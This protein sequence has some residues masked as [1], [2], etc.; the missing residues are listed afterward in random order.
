MQSLS[1]VKKQPLMKPCSAAPHPSSPHHLRPLFP[2]PRSMLMWPKGFSLSARW[3][4][5]HALAQWLGL[6][7][8]G[9]SVKWFFL[10]Q[11][12]CFRPS[13]ILDCVAVCLKMYART[14]LWKPGEKKINNNNPEWVWWCSHLISPSLSLSPSLCVCACLAGLNALVQNQQTRELISARKTSHKHN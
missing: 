13:D 3:E 6:D 12:F 5:T 8:F 14:L 1:A 10:M 11:A 4:W 9:G 2:P 7:Q